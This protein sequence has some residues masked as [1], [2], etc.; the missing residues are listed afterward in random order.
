MSK[1]SHQLNQSDSSHEACHNANNSLK[2]YKL[3]T[4]IFVDKREKWKAKI[5]EN[6]GF[7]SKAYYLKTS[8]WKNLA[9][10]G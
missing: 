8:R 4:P 3:P 9:L 5:A 6:E 7:K 2:K 1:E 10:G